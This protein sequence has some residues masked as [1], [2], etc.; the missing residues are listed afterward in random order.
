[1]KS[2][3]EQDLLQAG[4]MIDPG[5]PSK[6]IRVKGRPE[7][8]AP[9]ESWEMD[10]LTAYAVKGL[11][12]A[13]ALEAEANIV[14]R[15]STVQ[16]FRAGHA[17]HI[18]RGKLKGDGQWCGWLKGHGIPRTNA[19]EAIQLYVRAKTEEAVAELTPTQAK[20]K[21]GISKTSDPTGKGRAGAHRQRR[22]GAPGAENHEV[23]PETS[24]DDDP[25][26]DDGQ[27][28][29]G[30]QDTDSPLTVLT[31]VADQLAYCKEEI[32]RT[33]EWP[34]AAQAEYES[35]LDDIGGIVDELSEMVKRG[36][37]GSN[38][39]ERGTQA[40]AA[41][42][43]APAPSSVQELVDD[44]ESPNPVREALKYFSEQDVPAE[45]KE[46]DHA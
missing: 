7:D 29:S 1:M 5:D 26:S 41:D 11:E 8:A 44:A 19:W 32:A 33:T 17:L 43:L 6:V 28:V 38:A 10:R 30:A 46:D 20:E 27:D 3:K 21:Y 24:D 35:V 22:Q 34:N 15:K 31:V 2:I 45:G 40:V 4:L 16:L 14:G 18:L 13:K 23:D 37:E 25:D 12:Q 36:A 42:N 39:K 9:S